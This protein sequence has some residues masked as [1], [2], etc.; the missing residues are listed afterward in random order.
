MITAFEAEPFVPNWRSVEWTERPVLE[1]DESYALVFST[2]A[3][4]PEWQLALA[5]GTYPYGQF[6]YPGV[7]NRDLDVGFRIQFSDAAT[8]SLLASS[9]EPLKPDPLN[10]LLEPDESWGE[11]FYLPFDARPSSP[12]IGSTKK[13]R[14]RLPRCLTTRCLDVTSNLWGDPKERADRARRATRSCGEAPVESLYFEQGALGVSCRGACPVQTSHA[15][16]AR[17]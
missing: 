4:D 10:R 17:R 5:R 14:R 7:A 12:R 13:D 11:R 16:E 2:D 6:P 15:V 9:E 1:R 3:H 8:Q